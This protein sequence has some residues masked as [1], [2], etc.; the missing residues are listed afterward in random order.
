MTISSTTRKAGPFDG[1]N[2]TV[3]FPFTFK[4]FADSDV[5]AVKTDPANVET[6]LILTTDYTVSLNAD[7]D[8]SPGGTVTLPSALLTDYKLTLTSD[9]PTLQAV[10]LTNSG[11]FYPT[12]INDALDRL[13]I[14]SQ[15]LAEEVNRSV[16]VPISSTT[17]PEALVASV[18]ASEA[19]AAESAA[20]AAAS[21]LA[22]EAAIPSGTLGFTPVNITG[23]TMT[24]GLVL[25]SITLGASAAITSFGN[26]ATKT[27]GTASGNVPLVGT[28]SATE[29]LAGLVE[30]A[31]STEL[32]AGT[33][34]ERA[35]TSAVLRAESI[36]SGAAVAA[37]G[38]SVDFT[39]VPDWVKRIT[40][41]LAGVSVSGA[42]ALRIQIGDSG[43]IEN[44]GY[45]GAYSLNL[46]TTNLAV[47]NLSSGF[48]LS[49]SGGTGTT[50]QGSIV[51]S[52]I[53][54]AVN[55]WAAFGAVGQSDTQRITMLGGSKALGSVLTQLRV[56]T[57]NGSDIFDAGT[58]NILYE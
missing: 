29:A 52:R 51:L 9:V 33:D 19:S 23:D 46:S 47:V 43:G 38:T 17:D 57:Q 39:A 53:D 24:G 18:T 8:T 1:N 31:S 34:A 15:E 40:V 3:A 58:I 22:A 20:A 44:T 26:A 25:P 55:S 16:K 32:K 10:E 4:V 54:P 27:T 48:D 49:G 7:Q 2:V 45:L 35:V 50:Y 5:V 37:S 56:T 13:T 14:F 30:L 41:M 12:V 36:V 11:G 6:T 28:T 42:S 21:A